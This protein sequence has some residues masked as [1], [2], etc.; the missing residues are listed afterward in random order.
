MFPSICVFKRIENVFKYISLYLFYDFYLFL[1]SLKENVSKVTLESDLGT[2]VCVPIFL[3]MK[4]RVYMHHFIL[5]C[6]HGK[7]CFSSNECSDFSK[8]NSLISK[9]T[10]SSFNSDFNFRTGG[11]PSTWLPPDGLVKQKLFLKKKINVL[12]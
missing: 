7:K 6:E 5:S 4:P 3:P 9:T 1:K 8:L 10:F 11:K 2:W 12:I